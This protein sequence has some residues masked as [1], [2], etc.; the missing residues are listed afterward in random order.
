[1]EHW[2]S[3][4]RPYSAIGRRRVLLSWTGT[5]FEYL[6]PLLLQRSYGGSLL[7]RAAREAVAVHIAYGRKLHVPWGISE[8]AY[9]DLDVNKTYQYKA[10]GVPELGLKRGQGK[11]LVVAPYASLLAIALAPKKTVQNLRRLDSLGLLN[12]YGY[13]EA[14]DFGRQASR[15]GER[16]VIVRAYLAHHQGMGFLSM[17]NFLHGNPIQRHFHADARVRAVE[18]LLHESV[19]GP[20]LAVPHLHAPEGAFG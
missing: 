5:M 9:T 17:T 11:E 8:S 18:P 13:Y 4:G 19:P 2:F 3:M 10:F 14:I 1:M 12:E 20:S 7:D 16:G 6:M 15:E